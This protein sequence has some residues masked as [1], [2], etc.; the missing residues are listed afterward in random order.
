MIA[1]SN[2]KYYLMYFACTCHWINSISINYY[3]AKIAYDMVDL[4]N[5]FPKYILITVKDDKE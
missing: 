2:D 4:W 3:S 5:I 1:K